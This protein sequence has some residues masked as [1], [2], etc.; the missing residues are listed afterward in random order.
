MCTFNKAISPTTIHHL[1][2]GG[3][4]IHV[5][6]N[7]DP[8]AV[9]HTGSNLSDRLF[10]SRKRGKGK[11]ITSLRKQVTGFPDDTELLRVCIEATNS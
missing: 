9:I 2:Q 11:D 8:T 10:G 3:P 7:G 6:I 1:Q 5:E 4:F